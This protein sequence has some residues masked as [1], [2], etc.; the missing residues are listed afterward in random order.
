[1]RD[2]D[3]SL[4]LT[5]REA[6]RH[7]DAVKQDIQW[8]SPLDVRFR[9]FSPKRSVNGRATRS[10]CSDSVT[11]ELNDKFDGMTRDF[12]SGLERIRPD[13]PVSDEN[14]F[15]GLTTLHHEVRHVEQY[16]TIEGLLP[17]R[18]AEYWRDIGV[19]VIAARGNPAYYRANHDVMMHEV[20]ANFAAVARTY[21]YLRDNFPDSERVCGKYLDFVNEKI[22]RRNGLTHEKDERLDSFEEVGL[23]FKSVLSDL[24]E[25]RDDAFASRHVPRWYGSSKLDNA[26]KALGLIRR[27]KSVEP[28]AMTAFMDERNYGIKKTAEMMA[29]IELRMGGHDMRKKYP[30]L[31]DAGLRPERVFGC[32]FS[33][34]GSEM[35]RRVDAASLSQ[36][37][38][39][40]KF[41]RGE[42]VGMDRVHRGPPQGYENRCR[43]MQL[44]GQQAPSDMEFR[45]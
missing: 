1:M 2:D 42:E 17:V 38:D 26:S 22:C 18:G 37:L 8:G 36:L 43:D 7:Y 41:N 20:D 30:V 29:C 32:G 11:V 34:R 23:A 35:K 14:F 44:S 10:W 13:K 19:S 6:A 3:Y 25:G 31:Q 5:S 40:A 4:G 28:A 39:V 16:A 33:E 21:A 45:F 24:H 12:F 9:S 27:S 15:Q